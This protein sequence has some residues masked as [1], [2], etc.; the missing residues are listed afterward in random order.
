MKN[1]KLLAI[2]NLI[3]AAVFSVLCFPV[4]LDVSVCALPLSVLY[5][6]AMFFFVYKP[7]FVKESIE[8]LAIERRMY[9]YE[10]FV[11]ISAF[12]LQRAGAKG[13]P[14]AFDILCGLVW[15]CILVTYLMI[16]YRI[17]EKR[18]SLVCT[19]WKKY[20]AEHPVEKPKG[21]G[22]IFYEIFDWLD[23][24]IQ[25]VFT[26]MLLNIFIFQLY[27]IPSESMVPTFL[28]KDRVF[29]FKLFT[30]PK[31]PLSEA[32]IPYITKYKKGDIV[33]FRNPHYGSDRKSEVKTFFSNFLS[34]C[35]LTLVNINR[36]ENGNVK[37]D[38]LVKRVAGLPGEQLIMMDG[39]L[40]SRKKGQTEF[41]KS[42]VDEQVA[43]WDLNTLPKNIRSHILEFPV[44]PE[45]AAATLE[46]EKNRRALDLVSAKLEC[47]QITR[48]FNKNFLAKNLD[49]DSYKNL[50]GQ[51]NLNVYSLFRNASSIT[52]LLLTSDGGAQWFSA[53][54]ND[55]YSNLENLETF[56]EDGKI[57][58]DTLIGGDLYT[59]SCFRLNVMAKLLFGRVV[60]K[61][62]EMKKALNP[63]EIDVDEL[64]NQI[65]N[66][67][68]YIS[69]M[70][71]RNMGLFPASNSDGSANY[72]PGDCYFMMGDNRYNSLDMRHSYSFTEKPLYKADDLSVTYSSN[73]EPQA[74]PK[75]RILG[76]ASYR[77]W[78]FNRAGVPG[79][80][81]RG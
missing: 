61:N 30:G 20:R 41:T 6:V 22:R 7:L 47:Q 73:L 74:V 37:A 18:L 59:D 56:V 8:K 72:L 80:G 9:E 68:Y 39:I 44:S 25:T 29:V 40:Y 65:M 51:K 1:L 26:I 28:V 48:D 19:E 54:M 21:I 49:S 81:L 24:L 53:F 58:G 17:N 63:E 42:K 64:S 15:L 34:M 62:I 78:P 52:S 67:V 2:I 38:P 35:T 50:I 57:T 79:K 10:P 32:G 75:S 31:L 46:I 76:K 16:Q 60:L 36:D 70:D 14:F 4:N 45:M 11:Y 69:S 3:S 23:A 5:T 71:Q 66:L 55:W 12:V 27:V 33:V 77:F 43:A 13:L